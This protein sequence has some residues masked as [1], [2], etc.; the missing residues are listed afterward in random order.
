VNYAVG[1]TLTIQ[2][3]NTEGHHHEIPLHRRSAWLLA[4][5]AM[6]QD[7]RGTGTETATTG[8]TNPGSQYI[9][10]QQLYVFLTLTLNNA[11]CQAFGIRKWSFCDAL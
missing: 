11:N 9:R 5:S 2:S 10:A 6:A 8:S 3:G 4:G 7:N 1:P